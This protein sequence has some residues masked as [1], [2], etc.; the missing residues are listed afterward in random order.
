MYSRLCSESY[1]SGGALQ[2]SLGKLQAAMVG[3]MNS[4]TL[5]QT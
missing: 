5:T 3:R 1:S 4:I 2:K